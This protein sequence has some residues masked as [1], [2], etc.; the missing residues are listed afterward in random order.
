MA[1]PGSVG[2][3]IHDLVH[4]STATCLRIGP[5]SGK[6]MVSGCEDGIVSLWALGKT[7]PILNLPGHASSITSLAI[8]W[9]EEYVI[10]GCAAGPIKLW[11]LQ[12]AKVARTLMGHKEA[13]TAIEFH[14]FGDF[15]VSGGTEAV[16]KVW[17]VKK[18]GCIQ[19]YSSIKGSGGTV[20]VIRITPDGRWIASGWE[21]GTVKVGAPFNQPHERSMLEYLASSHHHGSG[22]VNCLR[23]LQC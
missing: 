19:T 4:A 23:G 9:P 5:K 11:D 14:P 12:H 8:D 1:P 2:A 20:Q 21:D 18:K 17:D 22:A 16:V 13:T 10:V 15:F 3:K 7:S 6:V